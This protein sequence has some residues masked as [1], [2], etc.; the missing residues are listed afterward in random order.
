MQ[1]IFQ[2]PRLLVRPLTLQD[3]AAFHEMQ[4]DPEVM[5]YTTGSPL[6]GF[7]NARQLRHCIDRYQASG[8]D[9]FVWAAELKQGADFAGTC[10]LVKN[11]AGENE[12]GYRLLRRYWGQGLGKEL[13]S[14]LLHYCLTTRGDTSIVA[15]ADV[16]NAASIRILEST[17]TFVREGPHDVDGIL[18][19]FYERRSSGLPTAAQEEVGNTSPARP[20]GPT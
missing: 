14:G 17:M 10:A 13:A 15:H 8:N 5:R 4:S 1:I 9:F 2:T 12:I 7:E 16:R 19:R 20:L 3:E 6:D 11:H 18:V